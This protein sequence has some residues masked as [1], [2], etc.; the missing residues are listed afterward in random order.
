M[1]N[2]KLWNV[3]DLS[4][5]LYC[6]RKFYLE[7][8]K[9][10]DILNKKTIWILGD[11][12]VAHLF[13]NIDN[14]EIKYGDYV[15]NHCSVVGLSLNRFLKS[16]NQEFLKTIPIKEQDVICLLFGEIDLR[17]TILKT[18]RDKKIPQYFLMYN[19]ITKYLNFFNELKKKY[20]NVFILSP[21]GV[22]KDG[23]VNKNVEEYFEI[24]SEQERMN[25]WKEF[26]NTMQKVLLNN[27][28]DF[29]KEIR[30]SKNFIHKNFL[31]ENENKLKIYLEKWINKEKNI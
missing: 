14:N 2:K 19:I 12:H 5:Y 20:K 4:M 29:T 17:K 27:Y 7:K 8:I 3:T 30:D 24:D 28:I 9:G 16:N 6:P 21:N 13:K 11:S 22:I 25:L 15:F 26:N 1:E 10:N 18:S 31:I 23:Q